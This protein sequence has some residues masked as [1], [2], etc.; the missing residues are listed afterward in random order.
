MLLLDAAFDRL[1]VAMQRIIPVMNKMGLKINSI[2]DIVPF[3]LCSFSHFRSWP[4]PKLLSKLQLEKN[5]AMFLCLSNS[6]FFC[7]YIDVVLV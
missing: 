4:A 2:V 3:V 7:S 5:R 6:V 1:Q